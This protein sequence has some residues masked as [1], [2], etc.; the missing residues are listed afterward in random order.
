MKLFRGTSFL[1]VDRDYTTVDM[2]MPVGEPQ[3]VTGRNPPGDLA[4]AP[5]FA[6]SETREIGWIKTDAAV[7]ALLVTAVLGFA[8]MEAQPLLGWAMWLV[9]PIIWRG[10][11]RRV[12]SSDQYAAK[13]EDLRRARSPERP[14]RPPV[15]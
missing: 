10:R 14:Q 8:V 5:R 11:I 13:L 6:G 15:A 9:V 1:E 4:C 3:D 12:V 2:Y 7:I